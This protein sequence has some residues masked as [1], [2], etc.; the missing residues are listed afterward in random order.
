M[1]LDESAGVADVAPGASCMEET[2][3]GIRF[4]NVHR[5][6]ED[7]FGMAL[8]LLIAVSPWITWQYV[9]ELPMLN[10]IAV[11]AVVLLLAESELVNLQRWEESL[12]LLCGVWLIA[13]PFMFDYAGSVLATWHFALGGIVAVLAVFELWQDWTLSDQDLVQHGQ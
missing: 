10:A 7:W 13:S 6:W 11:G 1:R 8:G 3:A 9:G 4:F 5:T 2:M 12:E